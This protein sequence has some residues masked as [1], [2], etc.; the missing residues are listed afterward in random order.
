LKRKYIY[1][2]L[3][4]LVT[5]GFYYAEKQIDANKDIETE[6]VKTED[7]NN[8]FSY[9]PTSTTGNIVSH[10]N[11]SLSY[12]EKHEQSEWVAYELKRE[13]I[14]KNDYKRPYFEED[15]SVKSSSAD[16]KNY[17]NSGY[18]K[19]HLCPAGD[20]KF[21][22]KAFQETFLTSNISPQNHEFNAGIW[23]RLEQK[24]RYWAKKYNGVYVVTGGVLT[25][26]LKTIGYEHVSV[27]NYFYKI[28]LD[29]GSKN[30][31]M[32]AFMIPHKNTNKPLEDFVVSADAIE[33]LTGINFFGSLEDTIEDKLESSSS[34]NGWKF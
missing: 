25:D 10:K 33:K 31:K 4:S 26:D 16:W 6:N 19:G 34:I 21:T 20:R 30:P 7:S 13:H 18:D 23:N 24:T 2:L 3:I 15:A 9:L 29:Y 12:S 17:K 32:I 27:P 1:P 8:S 11:Y 14:S 28:L 5:I 22:F